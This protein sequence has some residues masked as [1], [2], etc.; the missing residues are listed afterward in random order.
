MTW[1]T[2]TPDA[3]S[4]EAWLSLLVVTV[5]AL[6][7]ALVLLY[8]LAMFRCSEHRRIHAEGRGRYM[9]A[10]GRPVQP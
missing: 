7:Y 4:V 2:V 1:T 5:V 6:V 10:D 9:D 8:R 3:V